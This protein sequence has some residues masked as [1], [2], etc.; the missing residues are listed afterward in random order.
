MDSLNPVQRPRTNIFDLSHEL[1][2]TVDMGYLTPMLLLEALPG[3][4]FLIK[5]ELI[6]R[7]IPQ[8]APVMHR[9]HVIQ[10]F[11]FVPTRILWENDINRKSTRRNISERT[12][13]AWRQIL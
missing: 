2:T 1:K 3:D 7:W 13:T 8:L 12:T 9:V 10:D 5:P 4:K 6:A 11:Y